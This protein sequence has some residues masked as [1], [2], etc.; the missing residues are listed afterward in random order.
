[1]MSWRVPQYSWASR[2]GRG[3]APAARRRPRATR[4]EAAT[5]GRGP[6]NPRTSS[7]GPASVRHGPPGTGNV[8]SKSTTN[9][10][11]PSSYIRHSA[12]NPLAKPGTRNA[13]SSSCSGTGNARIVAAVMIP[14]VPSVPMNNRFRSSPVVERATARVRRTVPSART[15]SSPRT[16]SPIDPRRYAEY[17]TPF[18]PIAPPRVARG[19]DHG[20]WPRRSPWRRRRRSRS[21]RTIPASAVA[22][23]EPRSTARTRR[24]L[25]RSSTIASDGGL[26]PPLSPVPPPHATTGRWSRPA[27]RRTA[28]TS[29]VVIGRTTA[30]GACPTSESGDPRDGRRASI[31]YR[32]G[33]RFPVSTRAGRIAPAN[34]LRTAASFIP[35]SRASSRAYISRAGP[36]VLREGSVR[37]SAHKSLYREILLSADRRFS[38]VYPVTRRASHGFHRQGG[39][40][41]RG[42]GAPRPGRSDPGRVRVGRRGA[43]ADPREPADEREDHRHRRGRDEHDRPA[44]RGGDHR[45]GAVRGEHGRA[46]PPHDPRAPQDPPRTPRD[47]RPRRGRAAPGRGGGGPRG[48]GGDPRGPPGGGHGLPHVRARGRHGD[49]RRAVRRTAIEGDGRPDDRDLHVPVPGGGRDPRGERGVRPR[50]APELRGHGD[51][52]P[53]R[54]ADR[55]RPAPRPQRGVQGRGRRPDAG[56]QGDHGGDHEARPRE[57]RLQRH[58]D[59]HEGRGRRD[60][61]PR[62]ERLGPPGGGGDRGSDQQPADR[63]GDLGR[64][65]RPDQRDGRD[66]HDRERGGEGRRGRP[67][68]DL[69]ERA[70][71]LGRRGGPEP[72][73][74]PPGDADPHGREVEADLRARRGAPRASAGRRRGAVTWRRLSTRAG[75]CN[76]GSR[77]ERSASAGAA[78]AASSRWPGSPP[79]TSTAAS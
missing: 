3:V 10:A 40:H 11:R 7:G 6:Q 13:W 59:D 12:S 42:R 8:S 69:P 72:P 68:P 38:A 33:I 26:A 14:R 75:T 29:A 41:A 22:V 76:G 63:R 56:D 9:G 61:R 45:R 44:R 32:G 79:R 47:P 19:R 74:P 30:A 15:A 49:R 67:G 39:H 18:V 46:A 78:T 54:Q 5:R 21:S 64:D 73:A 57:P 65:G 2:S 58:Q 62:R 24:I 28:E 23:H 55:A 34:A 31:R 37:A 16:W 52:D 53:E 71:H 51:R 50:E 27:I 4:H 66:G 17:P 60:D 25:R 35:V 70:D 36:P 43:R 1:M 48:G 20:S 77:S